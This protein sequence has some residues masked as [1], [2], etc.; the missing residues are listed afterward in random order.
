MIRNEEI[1]NQHYVET[2]P[3]VVDVPIIL[4]RRNPTR[5]RVA[6]HRAGD[7]QPT[8]LRIQRNARY[9]R[10][11]QNNVNRNEQL[12]NENLSQNINEN[13]DNNMENDNVNNIADG[14]EVEG[15]EIDDLVVNENENEMPFLINNDENEN[16]DI[17][18]RRILNEALQQA[19]NGIKPFVSLRNQNIVQK[20]AKIFVE[21]IHVNELVYCELC[22]ENWF[23]EKGGVKRNDTYNCK[24]CTNENAEIKKMS[25][26]NNM[27]PMWHDS[28][29][30]RNELKNLQVNYKLTH[31]EEALIARSVPIMSFMKLK[32]P[33]NGQN[34]GF[35]GNVVNILQDIAPL[36][37]VLPRL[38]TNIGIINIRSKRGS[39]PSDY[40]D[41]KVRRNH[42]HKWLLFLKK[43]NKSYEN[44]IIDMENINILPE[45]G[46]I[47]NELIVHDINLRCNDNENDNNNNN[48]D[49]SDDDEG[50]QNG[51]INELQLDQNNVLESGLGL[52]LPDRDEAEAIVQNL[53]DP[54]NTIPW[55]I[56][57][58]ECIDEYNTPNILVCSFPCYFPF[59]N[60]D[61]T[62]KVR[63]SEVTLN[64]AI[65]HYNKY[66][67]EDQTTGK[68]YYPLAENHKLM[69]LLQDMDER[70]R[71]QSQA[72][73]YLQKN[74]IDANL[75]INELQQM[76]RNRQDSQSFALNLR[77]QTFA[78]NILGKIF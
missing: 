50:I 33:V 35:S 54:N 62:N 16:N 11:I 72:S 73:I 74:H 23:E 68:L 10:R 66:A 48:N 27:S 76:A 26:E 45:N 6:P 7:S 32:G 31:T 65:K 25:K 38:V 30:A 51:P 4:D 59:G 49:E 78:A 12:N 63:S 39:E 47:L 42:I 17:L 64:E 36:C 18:N 15:L 5:N 9:R 53:V 71:I 28:P 14:N 60:G 40:K 29:I 55:P 37:A 43:W 22:N 34:M 58:T 46:S 69:H 67:V 61:V 75:T 13:I 19:A 24:R 2:P 56:L 70:H 41:F 44:I 8:P 21:K 1:Q 52:P 20:Y 3:A 57:G 77:M